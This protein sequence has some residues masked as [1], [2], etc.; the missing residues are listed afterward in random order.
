M[1]GILIIRNK[2][3]EYG[4]DKITMVKIPSLHEIK[5]R[6]PDIESNFIE[7]LLNRLDEDY[8]AY[9]SLEETVSHLRVISGLSPG[10]PVN[11]SAGKDGENIIC[12]IIGYDSPGILSLITGTL[13]SMDF[14]AISGR[15]F[16]YRKE[17]GK[18][19]RGS[20][21]WRRNRVAGKN[22][23][24]KR[25]IID[26]FSGTIPPSFPLNVW[27]ME[28]QKNL[29][30]VFGLLATGEPESVN[31][32]REK[33]NLLV[34]GKIL[35]LRDTGS[36]FYPLHIEINNNHPDYTSMVITGIDTPFFLYALT[37]ALSLQNI[38]IERVNISTIKSQIVDEFG[39]VDSAG[40]KIIDETVL[41]RIKFSVLLTKQFTYF[42]DKAPD[43]YAA[44]SR[45]EYL[46]EEIISMQEKGSWFQMLSNP[47]LLKD[48]AKILGASD[49]LWEDF[50]R[51]QY[52][53]ILPL[54]KSEEDE[55]NLYSGHLDMKERLDAALE[56][57][58]G[59]E[60]KVRMLNEF[61]DRETFHID[62]DHIINPE[63]DFRE[64]SERLTG[65]ANVVLK[66]AV[67]I[68][69]KELVEKYGVPRSVAG[70]EAKYSILGLGK[71]GGAAIGYA[72][73]IELLVVYSDSGFTDGENSLRNSEFFEFMV[74]DIVSFIK[75][76]KEGIFE[77]DLRLRPYG[78]DGPLACSLDTFCRYYGPGGDA[79]S[80]EKLALVRMRPVM[81]DPGFGKQLKR[82]RNDFIYSSSSVD[83]KELHELR[84]KQFSEIV[85]D[86]RINA[87]FSPGALVDLEYTVQILQ[88][89]H[90][91]D[92][93][94][95]RTSGIHKALNAMAELGI[96]DEH[97]REQLILTYDFFRRLINGLRMLRGTAKDLFLPETG[98]N[99]YEHLAR[100]MG[101]ENKGDLSAWQQLH[102]EF[103]TRSAIIRT[104]I[105]KRFGRDSLPGKKT[106]NIADLV[107]SRDIDSETAAGILKSYGFRNRERAIHN[108]RGLAGEGERLQLFA[109]LAV[110]ATDILRHK[111]NPD[112]ALNNWERFMA[113]ID[114]P[115]EHYETMLSQPAELDILLGIFSASQFLSDT[116]IKNPDFLEWVILPENIH[117]SLTR[118]DIE[119]ELRKLRE[120]SVSRSEWLNSIRR[121]KKR[122]I[123]RIG[124]RD[125]CLGVP[126]GDIV[127]DLSTLAEAFIQVAG[128]VNLAEIE[129][130]RGKQETD[131]I[132]ERFSIMAFGKL[133]GNELNYSSDIDLLMVYDS[134]GYTGTGMDLE[135]TFSEVI[136]RISQDLSGHHEEGHAYRV[137]LRLR[138]YG[139]SGSLACSIRNLYE[140]YRENSSLWEI[141]ALLKLRPVAGNIMVGYNFLDRV[142]DLFKDGTPGSEI[143][144]SIEKLRNIAVREK[145]RSKLSGTDVKDGEG[146][147]RD[148]EF[149]V[150]GLQMIHIPEYPDLIQGNT[151][152]ALTV[153]RELAL[154]DGE[155]VRQ[156][157]ED[158]IFLRRVEHYLQLFEDRQVHTLPRDPERLETLAKLMMGTE[159][160]ANRFTG[161]LESVRMRTRAAYTEQL[162]SYR[163]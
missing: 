158:Y 95:L 120:K 96:M 102:I 17:A 139:S 51:L 9:F 18:A 35:N 115:D 45:F 125:I 73:D 121:I 4:N 161:Y 19:K 37:S 90:G 1:P 145:K 91:K 50:I 113:V 46:T 64:L 101:Y 141:Q 34:T 131:E 86:S 20:K 33:V 49:F 15:I 132:R 70:L 160:D 162:G 79:H 53:N 78:K 130:S 11:V 100:R 5:N 122:E 12:T 143:V 10:K 144:N 112:M 25:V 52:E 69:Y 40:N 2:K 146:G 62:L 87:K 30:D 56:K 147:I 22:L 31:S 117:K 129:K 26:Q 150:Q 107:L 21:T 14:S 55:K 151:L 128:E 157:E 106:G 66:K 109:G 99:E 23:I 159:S 93:T 88:V 149:M 108:L 85:S 13:A 126:L 92:H 137:D 43:P 24:K 58:P 152:T 48:L 148:I 54:L 81:G 59:R 133:G 116:L 123:L 124:T 61:K 154:L 39:I 47:H 75:A 111:P 105:E 8:Y 140:Y 82:L 3:T 76:K 28:L 27:T 83:I 57:V 44:L 110:L 71:F 156:I 97:E 94:E 41:D 118:D 42:L 68:S 16:T 32:A 29:E 36:V 74:K 127:K 114:N 134:E 98:S 153:L 63:T 77:I 6:C 119:N 136:E 142:R 135:K 84:E 104:F 72:S 163:E 65:L 7:E 80:Y 67:E 89:I 38:L 138:P 103:D 60:E 155:L